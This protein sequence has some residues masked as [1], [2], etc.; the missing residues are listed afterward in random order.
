[1][2]MEHDEGIVTHD[3]DGKPLSQEE[4]Y[5]QYEQKWEAEAKKSRKRAMTED[6]LELEEQYQYLKQYEEAKAARKANQGQI[7]PWKVL[8]LV[9]G[10]AGI[11][12]SLSHISDS[13]LLFGTILVISAVNA[14]VAFKTLRTSDF[15]R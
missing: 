6:E 15:R 13:I 4:I 10:I 14:V 3:S 2:F 7:N 5:E 8:Y 12:Y 11:V 9:I 1:M